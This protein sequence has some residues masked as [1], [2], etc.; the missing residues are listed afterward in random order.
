MKQPSRP[1]RPKTS[2]WHTLRS[3]TNR[4]LLHFIR[5]ASQA[6]IETVDLYSFFLNY[7]RAIARQ[8]FAYARELKQIHDAQ[9][10]KRRLRELK[11]QRFIEARKIGERIEFGLTDQGA[12]TMHLDKLR[13][14]KGAG[15]IAT[16]IIFDVPESERFIRERFR[17]LIKRAG[18]KKLQQSVWMIQGDSYE[19]VKEL[20]QFL[21][22]EK[23][24]SVMRTS[25]LAH[26]K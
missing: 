19:S 1:S 6:T 3:R 7:Q 24:V 5:E 22:A 17:L 8:G 25:D 11:R 26:I 20:I 21:K 12:I 13:S 4:A 14:N 18:F 15:K 16:I 23:W 2:R 9:D 10:L